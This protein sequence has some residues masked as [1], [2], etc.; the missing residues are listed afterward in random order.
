[1]TAVE[2]TLLGLP[3]EIA[4][5]RLGQ[6]GVT[7]R[8]QRTQAPMRGGV[9]RTEGTERVIRVKDG[10]LVTALF[11]DQTPATTNQR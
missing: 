3:L 1:M 2:E 5:A 6:A 4:L 11:P 9:V 10:V 8:V 7:P